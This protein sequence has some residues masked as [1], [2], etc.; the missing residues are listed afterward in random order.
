[1]FPIFWAENIHAAQAKQFIINRR[2]LYQLKYKNLFWFA[3]HIWVRFICHQYLLEKFSLLPFVIT[4]YS[5]ILYFYNL[6]KNT[7]KHGTDNISFISNQIIPVQLSIRKTSQLSIFGT[8]RRISQPHEFGL[9]YQLLRRKRVTK[10]L[11]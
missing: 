10:P 8:S 7:L 6:I 3:V 1:M 11:F 9:I 2:K 5:H 4:Q